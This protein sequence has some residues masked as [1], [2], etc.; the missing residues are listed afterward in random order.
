MVY[1]LENVYTNYNEGIDTN[2]VKNPNHH[3]FSTNNSPMILKRIGSEPLYLHGK[4]S[5]E[6]IALSVYTWLP[7]FTK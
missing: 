3:S 4:T 1:Y 6:L 7:M 2:A 5:I